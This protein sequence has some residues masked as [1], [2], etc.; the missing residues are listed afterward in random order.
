[1]TRYLV[2]VPVM[3]LIAVTGVAKAQPAGPQELAASTC[4]VDV[5]TYTNLPAA[6]HRG[7]H[8]LNWKELAIGRNPVVKGGIRAC[9]SELQKLEFQMLTAGPK[10]VCGNMW[11]KGGAFYSRG[12]LPEGTRYAAKGLV[13]V[14]IDCG[15][16]MELMLREVPQPCPPERPCPPPPVVTCPECPTCQVCPELP[17]TKPP[18]GKPF[19]CFRSW[20]HG[21]VCALP[22]A[23]TGALVAG[24]RHHESAPSKSGG[25]GPQ[26]NDIN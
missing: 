9:E 10:Q 17:T 11:G 19:W 20:K 8:D 12:C 13:A 26:G 4:G 21:L 25:A 18:K 3:A 6:P 7:N 23:L 1:M 2:F 14:V 22:A 24:G 5:S 15:N 16:P